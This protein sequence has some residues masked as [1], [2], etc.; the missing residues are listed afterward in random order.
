MSR[1]IRPQGPPVARIVVEMDA[2]G[3]VSLNIENPLDNKVAIHPLV[4]AHMLS[5]CVP[6]LL[7]A[8]IG[9]SKPSTVVEGVFGSEEKT[10]GTPT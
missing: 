2:K 3:Q 9:P 5:S 8:M 10:N 4:A 1:I 6:S 7:Q